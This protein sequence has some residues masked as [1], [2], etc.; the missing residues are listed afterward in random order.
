MKNIYSVVCWEIPNE[1]DGK[2]E[3]EA[4]NLHFSIEK[5]KTGC[6]LKAEIDA[7]RCKYIHLCESK[8]DAE[9]LLE[10]WTECEKVNRKDRDAIKARARDT[11][12][13]YTIEKFG[14][15]SRKFET[16]GSAFDIAEYI[17]RSE[18]KDSGSY[19][20][21]RAIGFNDNYICSCATIRHKDDSAKDYIIKEVHE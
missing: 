10:F 13:T 6:N 9:D 1:T 16:N 18:L 12:R 8:K 7:M 21:P 5:F 15:I 20:R 14:A 3:K 19:E 17:Y 2:P 4:G 11:K